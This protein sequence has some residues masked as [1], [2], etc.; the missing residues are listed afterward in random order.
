MDELVQNGHAML[1][2]T[3]SDVSIYSLDVNAFAKAAANICD[4]KAG[5]WK[6]M[7]E[8]LDSADAPKPGRLKSAKQDKL[9]FMPVRCTPWR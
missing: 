9:V 4:D 8:V 5:A 1:V 7:K 2:Q 3:S 6:A